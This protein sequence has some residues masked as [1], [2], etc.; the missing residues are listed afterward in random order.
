MGAVCSSETEYTYKSTWHYNPEDQHQQLSIGFIL[1]H[2]QLHMLS[3]KFW[4]LYK[5]KKIVLF[6]VPVPVQSYMHILLRYSG[7][8][9]WSESHATHSWHMFYLS[10]NKVHWNQKP[11]NNVILNLRNVHC[12]HRC[13]RS[14]FSS[15]LMQPGEEFLQWRLKCTAHGNGSPDDILSICLAQKN[16]E[17]YP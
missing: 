4:G 12:V 16:R 5:C 7:Y 15:C 8:T 13:M 14:L 1:N 9:G 17:M 2:H 6:V 3:T 10:K 11:K